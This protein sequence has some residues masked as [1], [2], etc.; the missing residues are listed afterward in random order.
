MSDK[1]VYEM[2]GSTC[3]GY[4]SGKYL[5]TM[6]GRC[7]HY[8]GGQDDRYLFRMSDSVCE[9]FQRDRYFYTMQG[10]QCRWYMAR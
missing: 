9:F 2:Q 6:D 10:S 4:F 5:Y 8:R 1:H 3:Y 7:T